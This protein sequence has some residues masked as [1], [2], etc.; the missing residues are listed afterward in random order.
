MGERIGFAESV[1]LAVG[2]MVG[3]GIFAVLGVV[4]ANARSAAW[5]AFVASGALAL[6]AGYSFVRMIHE[7][8]DDLAGP[9]DHVAEFTGE[10]WLAGVVGWVFTFGYVGTMAMYAYAFGSYG[11]QL[12]GVETVLGVPARPLV[13]AL[14]VAAFVGLNVVG[15]RASGRA[16][17]ALVAAKVG[18]LLVVGVAGV[19]YGYTQGTL[20]SGLH[21]VG[22]GVV[23]AAALSFVA[24]EGWELLTFDLDSIENPEETVRKAIYAS[25]VFTTL[26]YVL[27][28]VVT[29]N[30]LSPATI[31]AH[32]ETALAY[33]AEPVFQ[34]AGFVLVAVAAVLSTASA[35]NATLFSAAHLS[36]QVADA[37][38]NV[39]GAGDDEPVTS[40][41]G[42]G[43]T[44]AD[45]GSESPVRA[46]LVLGT[47][48]AILTV[49]G[50][51]DSIT[52][53]ASGAFIS[54][55]GVISAVAYTRRD[56]LVSA[57]V[58]AVGALGSL[59]AVLALFW[60]LHRSDP[61]VLATVATIWAVVLAVYWLPRR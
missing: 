16:E 47:L 36:Q 7:S 34:E 44:S 15:A 4:A 50:S 53:F 5:L 45:D 57:V 18:I 35:L 3:G 20:D 30:L 51:L 14:G 29:T 28:A 32:A 60:H 8:D 27:V 59:V 40:S 23:S 48:T 31:T 2:G 13:S 26:L 55:F 56:S 43:R 61:D 12:V 21:H 19:Y 54:I 22:G 38:H 39:P 33:A 58:P 42:Q 41:V 6:C 1:S 11:L 10:R 52:S 25:I 37:A 17:D 46:L 24:F 49:Y 9:V